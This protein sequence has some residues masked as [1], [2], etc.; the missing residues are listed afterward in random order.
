MRNIKRREFVKATAAAVTG[1]C[2]SIGRVCKGQGEKSR[3]VS[4]WSRRPSAG[5]AISLGTQA[6]G[7]EVWQVT[8]E[9]FDQSNIY[10]EVPYCSGDSRYFVY[11][12]RNP[13]LP[14]GNKTEFMAVELGTWR[15]YQLDVSA[16]LT[17]CAISPAGMFYYL[18]QSDDGLVNL[19]R[20]NLATGS[21]EKLF[22]IHRPERL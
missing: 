6:G 21:P 13:A 1:V 19:M 9:K 17:G 16:G 5:G 11:Q 3:A 7:A 22:R 10:C 2:A 14:G 18:K 15:Q 12:R 4:V 20:A 8:T